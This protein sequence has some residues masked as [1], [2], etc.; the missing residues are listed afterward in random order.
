MTGSA[1]FCFCNNA[2]STCA[3]VAFCVA[4]HALNEVFVDTI[5]VPYHM[6]NANRGHKEQKRCPFLTSKTISIPW[7]HAYITNTWKYPIDSK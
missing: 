1:T 7:V 4:G 2:S 5:L 6:N 3:V